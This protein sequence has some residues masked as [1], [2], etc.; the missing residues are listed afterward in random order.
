MPNA[1]VIGSGFGGLASALRLRRKGYDVLVLER[2]DKLGGRAYTYH[3][4]GF[5][6]DA[7]PTVITAPFLLEEL[8]NLFQKKLSDYLQ[9]VPV[10]PWYLIRF[11]DGS[12][13]RYGG[14]L[15]DTLTQVRKFRESD[16]EGYKRLLAKCHKIFDIGFVELGDRPFLTPTS[17][18]KVA[19]DMV[20][21]ESYLTVHQLVSRYI[22]DERLRQVFTFHPLLVGGNPFNTTSI[23]ALIHYLER[24]YGVWYAMGG[25]GAIVEAL[26]NLMDE[27][28]IKSK[29][30]CTVAKIV[31]ENGTAVGVETANGTNFRADIVVSNADPPYVYKNMIDARDKKKWTDRRVDRMQYSMGLFVLYFG[32]AKLYPELAH[33]TILLGKRYKGLLDDIF[34]HKVLADDFSLYLHAPTRTDPSMAPEGHECFYVLAP[35]PN[36]QSKTDWQI[37]GSR[38][39]SKILQFLENTVLPGLSQHL[40][41]QFFVTPEHFRDNL[42]SQHGSGFS[43]QPTLLQSAYFR[44][45][46]KSEDVE[47]LYFV[48]AGT[49]PGAGMPG[50]LTSAKVLDRIVPD[51]LQGSDG[52]ERRGAHVLLRD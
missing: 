36:L 15:E 43:V 13:F 37:E 6:Y 26:S 9:L 23:Y 21:L 30:S 35:V 5:T 8:F 19:P 27:V 2:Q 17:M 22:K 16:V 3:R 28:G 41:D 38:F 10:E 1:I 42:L 44:F 7:G 29:L 40:V 32:T 52:V 48:G 24:E 49:H 33:H 20:Q 39:A 25:T 12:T 45:H 11:D 34:H 47:N 31:T 51:L 14:T 46:N 50:V 18:V 4:K